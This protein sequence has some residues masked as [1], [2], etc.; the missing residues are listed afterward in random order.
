M[1]LKQRIEKLEQAAKER[2]QVKDDVETFEVPDPY[3][4]GGKFILK[5]AKRLVERFSRELEMVYGGHPSN[6]LYKPALDDEQADD[7]QPQ[8]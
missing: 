3:N 5:I 1:P 8:A 6:P 7:E 4:P 2:Q